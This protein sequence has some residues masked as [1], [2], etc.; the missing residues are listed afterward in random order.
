MAAHPGPPLGVGGAGR[1]DHRGALGLGGAPLTIA[2]RGLLAPVSS[3]PSARPAR[4]RSHLCPR[5]GWG[6]WEERAGARAGLA[7]LLPDSAPAVP[8]QR[9]YRRLAGTDAGE[10]RTRPGV[11]CSP[12]P[13]G[14]SE[15]PLPS[16]RSSR[17]SGLPGEE[18]FWAP[19]RNRTGLVP[20]REAGHHILNIG[21][22]LGHCV[23]R[24]LG[25]PLSRGFP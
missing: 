11:F 14:C 1:R 20:G 7:P 4:L 24:A 3:P 15:H 6:S 23:C 25:Y 16:S 17:L 5:M 12:T 10:G 18:R 8:A 22:I 9:A 19:T 2:E 13:P 21:Q